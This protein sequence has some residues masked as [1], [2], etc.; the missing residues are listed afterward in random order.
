MQGRLK[1]RQSS[2][3]LHIEWWQF[4]PNG[5]LGPGLSYCL[6]LASNVSTSTSVPSREAHSHRG[7]LACPAR[8]T[9][10]LD[11]PSS[12]SLRH[13][14]LVYMMLNSVMARRLL[15]DNALT[16]L[17]AA[18][19][20]SQNSKSLMLDASVFSSPCKIESRSALGSIARPT[21]VIS[22]GTRRP[23]DLSSSSA[24]IMY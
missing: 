7:F 21:L 24:F 3:S 2:D 22:L 1:Y 15:L 17:P 20:G 5:I 8:Y 14:P 12:F 4:G 19:W 16:V 18:S 23:L 9:R 13:K 10:H 6:W 11:T